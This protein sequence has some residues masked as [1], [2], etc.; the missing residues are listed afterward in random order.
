MEVTVS[1]YRTS[2]SKESSVRKVTV[3]LNKAT[4]V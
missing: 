4:D 3:G 1:E 2:N